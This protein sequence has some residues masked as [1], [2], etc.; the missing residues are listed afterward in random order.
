MSGTT[1]R[2]GSTFWGV[3]HRASLSAPL[4][5]KEEA[6][7]Q[8]FRQMLTDYGLTAEE[9]EGLVAAWSP[10]FFHAKGRR[11]ILRMSPEEYAKQCP[12]QVRPVPTEVVRLGLVLFEFDEGEAK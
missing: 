1:G 12:M 8:R 10:Q 11:F 2:E 5:L 3:G 4:P 9:A 6:L 7:V